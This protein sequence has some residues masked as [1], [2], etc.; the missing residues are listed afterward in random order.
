MLFSDEFEDYSDMWKSNI[1]DMELVNEVNKMEFYC[2]I[3]EDISIE[4][5]VLCTTVEKIEE[6]W[7]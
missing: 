1:T 2:P 6:V 4:D 7:V 3:V 5:N